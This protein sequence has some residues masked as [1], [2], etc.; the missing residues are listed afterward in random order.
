MPDSADSAE[1]VQDHSTDPGA[2]YS[3]PAALPDDVILARLL[4]LNVVRAGEGT[5]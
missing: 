5:A 4:A 3:W 2:A 1:V